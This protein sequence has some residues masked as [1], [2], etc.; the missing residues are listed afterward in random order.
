MPTNQNETI[1]RAYQVNK[2]ARCFVGGALLETPQLIGLLR[3]KTRVLSD[4]RLNPLGA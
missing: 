1:K 3:K 2:K 4:A